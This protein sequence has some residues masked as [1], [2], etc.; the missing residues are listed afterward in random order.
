MHKINEVAGQTIAGY[1]F[2]AGGFSLSSFVL[3]YSDRAGRLT[4]RLL[5]V[6]LP[7][8]TLRRPQR[9]HLLLEQGRRA[10]AVGAAQPLPSERG[11]SRRGVSDV[12]LR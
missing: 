12:P 8:L 10:R 11:C 4:D 7:Y 6:L 3:S 2:D 1:T 5:P 9:R